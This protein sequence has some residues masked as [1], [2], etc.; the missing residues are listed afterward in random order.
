M[1]SVQLLSITPNPEAIIARCARVSH[2]SEARASP[3]SDA[4]LIRRL[5]ELGHESVLE[6]ASATFLLEG[7]SRAC[8]NQLTRHRLA[9]FVQ[10]S[11]RYVDVRDRDFVWPH[12]LLTSPLRPGVESLLAQA[13]A[14]YEQALELGIPKE[15]ARYVLPL[16]LETRLVVA[17]NFRQWRHILKL[18][19]SAEAQWEIREVCREVLNI[20]RHHAP[21]VFADL[22]IKP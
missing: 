18:R 22:E 12:T 19:A 4:K 20:L 13:K 16:G 6:F 17:A 2:R 9:S 3:E 14:L 1:A 10:E 15:D 11:M 5:I 8:A 21:T 7:L